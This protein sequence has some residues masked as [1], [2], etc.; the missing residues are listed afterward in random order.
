MLYTAQAYLDA[1]SQHCMSSQQSFLSRRKQLSAC[2]MCPHLSGFWLTAAALARGEDRSKM[3]LGGWHSALKQLMLAKQV[4]PGSRLSASIIETEV[5]GAPPSWVLPRR[6]GK[7]AGGKVQLQWA[8]S[9]SLI[10]RLLQESSS[11]RELHL[12]SP[13]SAPIGGVSWDMV[14]WTFW[15]LEARG[16]RLGLYAAPKKIPTGMSCSFSF[17]LTCGDI[18]TTTTAAVRIQGD[19]AHGWNDF[20]DLGCMRGGWDDAA[21]A[22]LTGELTFTM[23]ISSVG[24][25]AC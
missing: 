12:R 13:L 17:C 6:T 7:Q 8:V 15:D 4:A 19:A 5:P 11:E 24:H 25:A 2:I 21:W 3:L 16:A 18:A 20:F 22:A 9:V 10:K 14:L 1:D 23:D